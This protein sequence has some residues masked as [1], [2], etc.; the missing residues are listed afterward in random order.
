[1]I[2]EDKYTQARQEMVAQQIAA[3]GIRDPLVLS[4]MAA[5]PRE[6]FVPSAVRAHA[7]QDMPL[8]IGEEQ[9]ISQPFIVALM[10]EA[11]WLQSG[12]RVLEVGAGSGYAA[13]VLAELAGEVFA[14]ERIGALATRAAANLKLAGYRGVRVKHG[15]GVLGWE[16]EAPFDAILV[17]AGGTFVPEQLKAQLKPGG[18][19]VIPVGD[20]PQAQ[21]LL[22]ITRTKDNEFVQDDLGGVRFVPLV[23]G[24]SGATGVGG[25]VEQRAPV[26]RMHTKDNRFCALT[27]PDR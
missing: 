3:R 25:A 27:T 18:R 5:V 24:Q 2:S 20:T 13:A 1:M 26:T 6:L 11:L 7:Y 15:D 9:T 16:E 12:D 8:P 22:C 14:I 23:G 19:M 10:A 21:R 17:S 4:A